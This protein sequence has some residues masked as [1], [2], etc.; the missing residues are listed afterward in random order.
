MNTVHRVA[1]IV[2]SIAGHPFEKMLKT[3]QNQFHRGIDSQEGGGGAEINIL[4]DMADSIPYLI[5]TQFQESIHPP[6]TRFKIPALV[7]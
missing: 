4:W 5:P 6:I 2:F 7:L 3:C 1:K